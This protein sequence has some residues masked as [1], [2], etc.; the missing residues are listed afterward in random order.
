MW[1]S[2][3][4]AFSM[5]SKIPMPK[6]DW[7]KENMKYAMVFFPFVGLVIGMLLVLWSFISAKLLIGDILRVVGYVVM[8]V[9]VTGGIHLDGFVDTMDAIN[10]Y[11]PIERKL[12]ILKDSHIGAFAL[13]SCV[14]YF[15][16]SL[17]VWSEV[18]GDSLIIL[19][20]GFILSRALSSLGI[21]TIPCAKNSGLASSFSKASEKNRVKY[22]MYIYILVSGIAMILV[23]RILGSACI[24][25]AIL[26]FIY[27]KNM[28]IKKF[29]GI[30]GD[31]A[32]Y[33]LQVCELVIAFTAVILSKLIHII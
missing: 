29:G 21:V 13:I 24:I 10:S 16:L 1:N 5:Y 11:Q 23:N 28:S 19:G 2:F 6:T 3:K 15:L 18:K 9:L 17:G 30:T 27:Y 8:P 20:I 33:F 32:G 31:L 25:S 7:N 22:A 12:E 26:T 14:I 4:I